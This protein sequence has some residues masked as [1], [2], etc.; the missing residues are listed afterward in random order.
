MN[1]FRQK[2]RRLEAAVVLGFLLCL[3]ATTV[4]SQENQVNSEGKIIKEMRL[5]GLKRTKEY[6]VLRELT[7]KVGEALRQENLDREKQKLELLDI[8]SDIQIETELV[9]DEVILTYIFV[10]TFPILPSLG[11]KISDENGVSVG[12]GVKSP[13]LLGRDIFF[14]GRA[15]FGGS[16]EAEVWIVNPWVTGN[17]LGYSL[18][19]YHRERDNLITESYEIANEFSLSVGSYLGENGRA[20]VDFSS[21]NIKSDKPGTTLSPDGKD[22]TT[23]LGFFL[24]YDNRDVVPD[25]RRGWWSEIAFN[26]D[27]RLF[28]NSSKFVQVDLDIRRF[29]P[30][31]FWDRHNLAFFSLTTLRTGTV[32]EDVAPWH[33]FGIGGT[34][35][36]RGWEFAA[37]K[38]KNQFINTV[39]YRITVIKPRLIH[40]PFKIKY[41]GGIG[42][43]VFGDLGIGWDTQNQ[44]KADKFIGGVGMGVRLLLPIVG[45]LRLDVGW[46]QPGKSIFL[47]IGAFEK[48]VMAR[49]RVR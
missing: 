33:V 3:T 42:I 15:L 27:M 2:S 19:Y 13:N 29:Q 22:H 17:H 36:V 44:F 23:R 14:S 20:G 38:G 21:I 18:E 28:K 5:E 16:K 11:L 35:T 4:Y 9:G 49:R 7:S 34:N 48:P 45:V 40:L 6:I 25:T 41:R 8:F 26:G 1:K 12:G 43:A 24:G 31:P 32:G 39:E 46:G 47:H 10:E 30:L 37:R